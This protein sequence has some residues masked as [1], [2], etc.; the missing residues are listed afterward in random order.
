MFCSALPRTVSMG[1]NCK[2][3]FETPFRGGLKA[4]YFSLR[5]ATPHTA[6]GGESCLNALCAI[7][8]AIAS[9]DIMTE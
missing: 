1:S 5:A 2:L 3:A 7:A 8:I 9:V 4:R 6:L